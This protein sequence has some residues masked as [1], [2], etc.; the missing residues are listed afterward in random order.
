MRIINEAEH[1]L[2]CYK[3]NC[4]YAVVLKDVREDPHT[5]ELYTRCPSCGVTM[6]VKLEELPLP[7]KKHFDDCGAYH[8]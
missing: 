4:A 2:Q 1:T 5:G 6:R 7:F 3:C 8:H